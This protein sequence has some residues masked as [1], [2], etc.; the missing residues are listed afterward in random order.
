ME[1]KNTTD[2]NPR[3]GH[4]KETLDIMDNAVAVGK[5]TQEQADGLLSVACDD[6]NVINAMKGVIKTTKIKPALIAVKYHHTL[7]DKAATQSYDDIANGPGG[8]ADLKRSAPE[9]YKAK[10]FEKYGR[11]PAVV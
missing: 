6:P 2:A 9:L 10:F 7:I 5:F 1:S 4:T 3:K 11:L 8:H